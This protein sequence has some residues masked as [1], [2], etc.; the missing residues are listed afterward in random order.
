MVAFE[1]GTRL[2]NSKLLVL[3]IACVS[4]RGPN[5]H[6]DNCIAYKFTDKLANVKLA[7]AASMQP[8]RCA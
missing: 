4:A 8:R 3:C 6:V 7:N 5:A 1:P 2:H